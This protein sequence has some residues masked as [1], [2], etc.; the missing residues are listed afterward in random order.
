MLGFR[1]IILSVYL[2][3]DSHLDNMEM[4][5]VYKCKFFVKLLYMYA[6]QF[7]DS[8]CYNFLLFNSATRKQLTETRMH[9]SR[10]RTGRTLSVLLLGRGGGVCPGGGCLPRG[11]WVSAR[12]VGVCPGGC[13][14]GGV[15]AQGG[16]LPGGGVC[17]GGCLPGGCLPP[18]E[19][20]TPP[21]DRM[22]HASENIT[23]AKTSFRPVINIL[24]NRNM[25]R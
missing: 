11:G 22:T 18:P 7:M 8:Q 6:P 20:D 14:P 24:S 15:S 17:P 25:K 3:M 5:L 21:V 9:S 2:L 13:L 16:C 1:W 10:M 19:S 23:L 12:G 4:F